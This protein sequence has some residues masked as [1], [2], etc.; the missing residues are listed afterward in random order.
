MDPFSVRTQGVVV[1]GHGPRSEVRAA[2]AQ[3]LIVDHGWTAVDADDAVDPAQIARAWWADDLQDDLD[4]TGAFVG[5][6]HPQ[7]VP[8]SVVNIPNAP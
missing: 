7:G 2:A 5:E 1:P 8:V 4:R 3:C 6:D